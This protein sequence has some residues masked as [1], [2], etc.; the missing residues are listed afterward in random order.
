MTGI[1]LMSVLAYG[2]AAALWALGLLFVWKQRR[3]AA[4]RDRGRIA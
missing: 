1:H 3:A 4:R 2:F